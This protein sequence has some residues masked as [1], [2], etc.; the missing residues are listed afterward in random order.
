[1]ETRI[2][3]AISRLL[4]CVSDPVWTRDVHGLAADAGMT[5]RY[6]DD[7]KPFKWVG[8]RVRENVAMISLEWRWKKRKNQPT[9]P[10]RDFFAFYGNFAEESQFVSYSKQRKYVVVDVAAGCTLGPH[11]HGHLIRFRLVGRDVE[12]WLEPYLKSKRKSKSKRHPRR[13]AR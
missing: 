1:M 2:T 3:Q 11:P 13:E 4:H 7:G 10:V 12:R 5:L 8:W 9:S 6:R